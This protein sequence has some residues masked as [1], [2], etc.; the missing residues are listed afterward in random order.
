[1]FTRKIFELPTWGVAGSGWGKQSTSFHPSR[2]KSSN[3]GKWVPVANH[4][5]ENTIRWWLNFGWECYPCVTALQVLSTPGGRRGRGIGP[6]KDSTFSE[7][8]VIDFSALASPA[9]VLTWHY[10]VVERTFLDVESHLYLLTKAL[11]GHTDC[12]LQK[13]S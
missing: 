13:G 4:E 11:V 8:N 7:G 5:D 3:K 1:M 6:H 10:A 12:H 2:S 9:C